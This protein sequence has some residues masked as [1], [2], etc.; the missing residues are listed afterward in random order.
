MKEKILNSELVYKGKTLNFKIDKIIL[1]N[2][3]EAKREI[4]EHPG[5]VA[6]LPLIGK[7]KFLFVKQFRQPVKK[8]LLEIPAGRIEAGENTKECAIREL[9]EETGHTTDNLKK[10]ASVYLAPGY[11]S[12]IIHIF[13][14]QNLKKSE[15]KP[16]EDE[17][18]QN[19][20]LGKKDVLNKILSGKIN[21]SKT[22]IAILLYFQLNK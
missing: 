21:D 12:E 19:M 14:A 8:I 17:L 11:S 5:S 7:N 6:I 20:I 9:A 10:L 16:D 2:G 18:I 13:L 4:V 1:P 3:R 22:I 15:A